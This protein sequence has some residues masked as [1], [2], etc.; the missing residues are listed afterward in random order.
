MLCRLRG[1]KQVLN[2]PASGCLVFCGCVCCWEDK[3]NTRSGGYSRKKFLLH[4]FALLITVL[5]ISIFISAM[6]FSAPFSEDRNA[7]FSSCRLN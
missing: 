6:S 4:S 1:T 7:I 5:F 2:L 3:D